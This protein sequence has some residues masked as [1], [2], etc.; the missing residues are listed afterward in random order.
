MR[1]TIFCISMI[2]AILLIEQPI[3]GQQSIM[4]SGGN[5]TGQGGSASYSVGQL[6]TVTSTGTNGSVA[7]GMQQPYEILV[8][9][10]ID[11]PAA[12]S[13][14]LIVYPNPTTDF[15]T[16][17]TDTTGFSS[18]NYHL[19]NFDGK[20]LENKTNIGRQT[21]ISMKERPAGVYFMKVGVLNKEMKTFKIIKY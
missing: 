3:K 14:D 13:I 1:K 7:P 6:L 15:L 21:K 19:Y 2:V 11:D 4:S 18:I 5:A 8:V 16:L 10:G 20:L 12:S 9:T 17:E